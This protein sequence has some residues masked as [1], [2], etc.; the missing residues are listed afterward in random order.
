[1]GRK[2]PEL[3]EAHRAIIVHEVITKRTPLGIV[4]ANS[5]RDL[6]RHLP[7]LIVYSVAKHALEAASQDNSYPLEPCNLALYKRSGAPRIL[8]NRN[9][10]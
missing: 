9:I 8:S 3:S 5:K 7:K 6:G 1:M 4:S 2:G 10:D